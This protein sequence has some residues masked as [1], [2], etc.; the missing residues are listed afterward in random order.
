VLSDAGLTTIA[1]AALGLA[2]GF[3]LSRYVETLLFEVRPLEIASLGFPL[4]ALFVA[5][6]FA[7][8]VP[9]LRAARV[10]PVVALRQD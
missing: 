6:L 8:A 4:A 1:G 5:T 9:A 10:D 2:G 7:A 3:Y